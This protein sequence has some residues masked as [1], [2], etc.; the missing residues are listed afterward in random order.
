MKHITH[1]VQWAVVYAAQDENNKTQ[2][3]EDGTPVLYI[4]PHEEI[5]TIPDASDPDEFYEA[6]LRYKHK[7]IE[8][9]QQ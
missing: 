5:C 4:H 9:N 2:T 8:E 3:H 6:D 7:V 1:M